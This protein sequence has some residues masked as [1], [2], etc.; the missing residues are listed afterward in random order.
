MKVWN[1]L[2]PIHR[3][4]PSTVPELNRTGSELSKDK[5]LDVIWTPS[6]R[7]AFVLH[8]VFRT[9]LELLFIGFAYWL[10]LKQ[11]GEPLGFSE[12]NND[13]IIKNWPVWPN[14]GNAFQFTSVWHVPERYICKHGDSID[15]PCFQDK[16][17]NPKKLGPEI[18]KISGLPGIKNDQFW[19][20]V[21]LIIEPYDMTRQNW[22]MSFLVSKKGSNLLGGSTT[23]KNVFGSLHVG[24]AI[25]FNSANDFRG[26]SNWSK[27]LML[28]FDWLNERIFS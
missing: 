18:S 19:S 10:Q 27:F 4:A 13:S 17:R 2:V 26:N 16:E 25:D 28:D 7:L 9:F 12:V 5:L 24:H 21:Q 23:W 14:K 6:I 11:N 20:M 3:P 22:K 8:L 15:S 1:D